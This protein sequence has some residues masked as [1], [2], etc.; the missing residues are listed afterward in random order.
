MSTRTDVFL[1]ADQHAWLT[2]VDRPCPMAQLL[3]IAVR[4]LVEDEQ[5][6][7]ITMVEVAMARNW[8]KEDATQPEQQRDKV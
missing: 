5:A 7:P 6:R 1:T 2:H 3:R 4:R 8:V